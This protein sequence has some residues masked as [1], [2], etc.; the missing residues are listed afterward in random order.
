MVI[1]TRKSSAARRRDIFNA[2]LKAAETVG[3]AHV[4]RDDIASRIGISGQAVQH[5]IEGMAKFRR[6][7]VRYAIQKEHLFTLAQALTA[8]DPIVLEAPVALRQ[9]ALNFVFTFMRSQ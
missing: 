6:D 5:H 3:Y 9:K 7:L 8:R 4:T 2:A 1:Q